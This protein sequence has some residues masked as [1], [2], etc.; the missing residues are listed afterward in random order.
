MSAD[1]RRHARSRAG[2]AGRRYSA[3][4]RRGGSRRARPACGAG[5]SDRVSRRAASRFSGAAIS[6]AT[7]TPI[8]SRR[9]RRTSSAMPYSTA[10]RANRWRCGSMGR[11]LTPSRCGGQCRCD[12]SRD[13]A[14]PVRSVPRRPAA[15]GPPRR[16]RPRPLHRPADRPCP[17]WPHCCRPRQPDPYGVL[18]DRPETPA[19]RSYFDRCGTTSISVDRHRLTTRKTSECEP[20]RIWSPE[21]SG[22]GPMMRSP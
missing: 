10:A 6:P 3:D 11:R 4:T 2:A 5:A 8:G 1:D 18:G 17:R 15:V 20:I 12:R 19:R 7:G 16:P 21:V 13:A 22:V 14:A 9:W